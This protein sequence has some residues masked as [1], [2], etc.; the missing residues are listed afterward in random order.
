M[1]N[2]PSILENYN[3]IKKIGSGSFGDVFKGLDK[4]TN[5]NVAIKVENTSK[6]PRLQY[7]FDLYKELESDNGIPKIEWFGTISKKNILIME[8]LGPSLDDLFEFC[9]K[10]FSLKT[11]S[12]IALQLLDRIE[13]IHKH[14]I[15]HR[16]IKPDNFLIGTGKNKNK[17]Y[18]IDLGLSKKFINTN[19]THIEYKKNKSFIGSFRYS[20]IRN[21]KGIEQSRRDDIESIGYMLIYFLKGRL[22]WQGLKGSTKSKRSKNI[23]QTKRNTSLETLCADMPPQILTYMKYCRLLSFQQIPDYNYL[24]SLYISIFNN[25]QF[26]YDNLFDW[27]I[28]A[29]K[30]RNLIKNVKTTNKI[31]TINSINNEETIKI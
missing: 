29:K 12:M 19:N 23:F 30:K 6:N 4:T 9:N 8:Y 13:F 2:L 10:Q 18:I 20:S 21:H 31:N 22:P 16:D 26:D 17:I 14:N 7:E 3:I 28:V 25:N 24:K 5:Q 11:V 27:R 15:I 1:K